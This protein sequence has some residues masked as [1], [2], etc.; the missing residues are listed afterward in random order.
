MSSLL[1]VTLFTIACVLLPQSA[2]AQNTRTSLRQARNQLAFKAPGASPN[3]QQYTAYPVTAQGE[4]MPGASNAWNNP[5]FSNESFDLSNGV[6]STGN[7]SRDTWTPEQS[8]N[9]NAYNNSNSSANQTG[10][11]GGV[12]LGLDRVYDTYAMSAAD[13]LAARRAVLSGSFFSYHGTQSSQVSR[14]R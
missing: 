5:G 1:L 12:G 9:A 4:I 13:V 14:N 8:G 2:T 3:N 10:A 11:Q 7:L 6:T